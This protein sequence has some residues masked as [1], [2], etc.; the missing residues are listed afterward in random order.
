MTISFISVKSSEKLSDIVKIFGLGKHLVNN[1]KVVYFV[2]NFYKASESEWIVE[3]FLE[4]VIHVKKSVKM[5]KSYLC[6]E[7][8]TLSTAFLCK[9]RLFIMVTYRTLVLWSSPK[10]DLKNKF[11][12]KKNLCVKFKNNLKIK[13]IIAKY[14]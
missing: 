4:K 6:T 9:V 7:L 13:G 3:F 8:C 2:Q 5:E 14:E 10:N 1:S 12:R 11:L